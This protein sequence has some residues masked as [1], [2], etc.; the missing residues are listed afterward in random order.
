M[1][2]KQATSGRITARLFTDPSC[3]FGYSASPALRTIE[4][5]YRDQIDWRLVMIGLSGPEPASHGMSTSTIAGYW[6]DLRDRHGMPF[7]V[8][9]K[10]RDN[11]S[12]RACQAIVAARLIQP[13][14]E[15]RT[16]RA[17]QLLQFNSPLLLDD[18]E[19]LRAALGSVDGLDADRIIDSLDSDEVQDAYQADF[20]ET[21]TAA[22]GPTQ[23]Q[24]KSASSPSGER[25]TA[26]SIIFEAGLLRLEAGGF[27]TIEAYDVIIANLDP[28]LKR[29]EPAESPL[30]AL[31]LYPSGLTTQEIAAIM[32]PHNTVPD[33]TA[34]E[35][36]LVELQGAGEV[37]R[38]TMGDDAL[39]F[40]A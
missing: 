31:V 24:G 28:T 10:I 32:A 7:L 12:A 14:S 33:R 40:A 4:W 38:V 39:W 35:R 2:E 6:I 27:Q 26:P 20:E 13:G 36:R 25:Y 29:A 22:D 15:W 18:D 11:T 21:R 19:Q 16:L 23:L 9:P 17:L 34:T 37:K 1:N 3:P 8:E 30:D 5:R